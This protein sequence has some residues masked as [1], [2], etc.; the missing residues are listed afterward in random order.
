MHQQ[1]LLQV[2]NIRSLENLLSGSQV[3]AYVQMDGL[4]DFNSLSAGLWMHL[5]WR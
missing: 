5:K 2:P 3:V 4:S 1:I